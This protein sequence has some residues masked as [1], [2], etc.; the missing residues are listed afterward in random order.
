MKVDVYNQ[1]KL[2]NI[3]ST[4]RTQS[5]RLNVVTTLLLLSFIFFHSSYRQCRAHAFNVSHSLSP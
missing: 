4:G 2:R 1:V 3:D 5:A